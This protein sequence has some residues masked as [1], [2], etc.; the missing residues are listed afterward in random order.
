MAVISMS[1]PS[2]GRPR[3][4]PAIPSPATAPSKGGFAPRAKPPPRTRSCEPQD[5]AGL[6]PRR[7]RRAIRR[8][9]PQD[10]AGL[11]PRRP[12][13]AI[14]RVEPQ[15]VAGLGPRRPRRA[16]RR[17]E[18]QDGRRLRPERPKRA[19]G[20]WR[21]Q[22]RRSNLDHV[23]RTFLRPARSRWRSGERRAEVARAPS[24]PRRRVGDGRF[25]ARARPLLAPAMADR[26]DSGALLFPPRRPVDSPAFRAESRR[27]TWL[28]LQP[29]RSRRRLDGAAL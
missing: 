5:V 16:I 24:S 10:V 25:D 20:S 18:P 29:G 19:P 7:P 21:R 1:S 9:E 15:D 13:R 12:R 26:R 28:R 6:G 8:T 4:T 27:G 2:A 3:S 17:I 14:R 11:G 22:S 23:T